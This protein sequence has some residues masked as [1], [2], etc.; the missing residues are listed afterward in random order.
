MLSHEIQCKE[1]CRGVAW[2]GEERVGSVPAARERVHECAQRRVAR[3]HPGAYLT[4]PRRPCSRACCRCRSS[5]RRRPWSRPIPKRSLAAQQ[6]QVPRCR[7]A[8]GPPRRSSLRTLSALWVFLCPLRSINAAG[9]TDRRNRRGTTPRGS[10]RWGRRWWAYQRRPQGP[11]GRP[12][13]PLHRQ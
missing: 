7:P 12:Q 1:W 11:S 8:R 3:T 6:P 2:A 10:H 9:T 4:W 13:G 5:P